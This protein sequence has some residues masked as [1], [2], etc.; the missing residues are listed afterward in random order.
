MQPSHLTLMNTF[1]HHLVFNIFDQIFQRLDLC[2]QVYL[3]TSQTSKGL[4]IWRFSV[5]DE[6]FNSA[7]RVEKIDTI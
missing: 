5:Q 4:I 3:E 7:K 1:Y 6:N 2:T